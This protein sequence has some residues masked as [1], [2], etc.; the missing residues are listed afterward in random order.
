MEKIRH[1]PSGRSR[2]AACLSLFHELTRIFCVLFVR[3]RG[4]KA[5]ECLSTLKRDTIKG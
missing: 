2:R 1:E 5:L 3:I 4:K